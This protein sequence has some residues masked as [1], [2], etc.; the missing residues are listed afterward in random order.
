[1][2]LL[3]DVDG[4]NLDQ[5]FVNL[6]ARASL[7]EQKLHDFAQQLWEAYE[8]YADHDFR[9]GFARDVDGRFWEM[10]L[11]CLFLEAGYSLLQ[12]SERLT[13]GGQPDLCI[14]DGE[15][16]IWIEAIAP[17][18]GAPGPDGVVGPRPINEG[19]GLAPSPRRQAQLRATSAFLTKSRAIERYIAEG[20]IA[21]A[22]VRIIAISASRF[23]LYVTEHPQPLILSA[24]FPFGEEFV[25]VNR[26]TG[27]IVGEGFHL[28]LEIQR[29]RGSVPRTAFLDEQFSHVS[30]VVWS[31]L[32]LGNTNREQRPITYVHNPMALA[33]NEPGW[34]PWDREFFAEQG[35]DNITVND[36]RK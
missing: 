26:D 22:D 7:P 35:D 24:L 29:E 33:P 27:Q 31:R 32:S 18:P 19:G 21:D 28:S 2:S 12:T 20:L 1:M 11:G 14:L 17:S 10:Y 34:G 15:R 13:E 8:P 16:R 36:I 30:G 4:E 25:T 6:R 23:G 9:M 3:F 5:G